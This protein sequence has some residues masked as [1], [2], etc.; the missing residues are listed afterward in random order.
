MA[1]VPDL[2]PR[3]GYTDLQQMPEDGR[4]Y[5]LYD[6]EVTVVPS[7]LPIHQIVADNLIV[8]L[9]RFAERQSGVAIS[10]PLDIVFSE[11]DVLQPDIVC[12]TLVSATLPDFVCPAEDVFRSPWD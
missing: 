7:P 9:R 12:D 3:V 10:S 5:E 2:K 4:R 6:G 1:P 8:L 11:Y